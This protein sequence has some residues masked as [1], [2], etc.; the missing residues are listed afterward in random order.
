MNFA[1]VGNKG[2]L[3]LKCLK[4]DF[5][6]FV[7]D[8]KSLYFTDLI[9]DKIPVFQQL[10]KLYS[11]SF[12]VNVL[13]IRIKVIPEFSQVQHLLMDCFFL[14]AQIEKKFSG[15]FKLICECLKSN[16][17]IFV[18]HPGTAFVL[19]ATAAR[20]D[21]T[22]LILLYLFEKL[23]VSLLIELLAFMEVLHELLRHDV[24]RKNE[25]AFHFEVSVN[26]FGFGWLIRILKIILDAF[27]P[28]FK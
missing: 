25:L 27:G 18:T 22:R 5:V 13:Q 4:I 9:V 12:V 16:L 3:L 14:L 23:L 19:L 28:H 1:V 15:H 17:S 20:I 8:V 2:I 21:R 26:L 7:L 10:L 24:F 11:R 6:R